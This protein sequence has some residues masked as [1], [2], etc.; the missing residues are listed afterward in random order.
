MAATPLFHLKGRVIRQ[1]EDTVQLSVHARSEAEAI[2]KARRV[3]G[4]YPKGHHVAG[5]PYVYTAERYDHSPDE[6]SV[7]LS[8]TETTLA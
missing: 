8:D 7:E 4:V 6:I 5:V 3:L 1:V 2:A